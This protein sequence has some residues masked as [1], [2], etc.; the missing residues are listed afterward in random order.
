MSIARAYLEGAEEAAARAMAKGAEDER[1]QQAA[2]S[3]KIPWLTEWQVN[4]T[5]GHVAGAAR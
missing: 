2:R 1:G 3:R 5:S 4:G